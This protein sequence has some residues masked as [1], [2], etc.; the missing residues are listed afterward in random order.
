MVSKHPTPYPDVHEILQI[1][2]D[3]VRNVLGE[4]FVG[5]YLYGSLSSGDFHPDASDIDFLVVTTDSLSDEIVA[6]LESMHDRIWETGQKWAAKLEGSYIPK[7]HLRRYEKSGVAYPTVNERKFYVA[8]HGS[9]WI[10]QRLIIREEGVILAGPD[11]KS[12]IDPVNP[13]DIR[14]A[15]TGILKEWWFPMLD[16]PSWLEKHEVPYHAY[17]I[18]TMCRALHALEHGTIVSKIAAANWAKHKLGDKW[19]QIIEHS[20][21]TRLGSREFELLDDALELIRYTMERVNVIERKS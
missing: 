2:L 9:D 12:M 5:L 4:Q 20:L 17:A 19:P 1:L 7:D 6:A 11:P 10:I 13:D 3:E 21:A 15:V 16:E 18:L 14:N 8:T